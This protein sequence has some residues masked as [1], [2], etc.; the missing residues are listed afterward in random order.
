LR[1]KLLALKPGT[2]IVSHDF[3]LEDWKADE[4]VQMP[5]PGKYGGSGGVSDIYLWIVPA[6]VA[7]AW[8]WEL[9]V[10][11]GTVTYVLD[12]QQR[13]QTFTGSVRVGAQRV[14]LQSARISGDKVEL[15][16]TA[17]VRG[18]P[19]QHRISGRIADAGALVGTAQISGPTLQAVMDFEARRPAVQ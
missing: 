17:N 6:K 7:G 3:S 1:P 4:H 14:P 13:F 11:G 18:S 8:R 16:F 2:R 12:A 15:A 9:P 5:A 10:R 19:V